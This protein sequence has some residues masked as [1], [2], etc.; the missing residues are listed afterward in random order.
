MFYD[1]LNH[2]LLRLPDRRSP[3]QSEDVGGNTNVAL[4]VKVVEDAKVRF[5]DSSCGPSF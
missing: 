4:S 1:S 2:N 3:R 5:H